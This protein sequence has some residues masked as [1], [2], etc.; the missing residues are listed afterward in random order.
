VGRIHSRGLQ[1]MAA[2]G[3]AALVCAAFAAQASAAGTVVA[4]WH[5]DET[6]GSTMRDSAG[7]ADGTLHNVRL[8]QRGKS[9]NA[10]GFNGSSSYV[11]VSAAAS[12]SLNPGSANITITIYGK[13][14]S[15][16]ARPDFDLIRKGAYGTGP[17]WKVEL[18]PSGQASCGFG[19]TSGS[20]EVIGVGPSIADGRWHKV[21]CKKT[22]TAIKMTVDGASFSRS[23]RIGSIS[24]GSQL[25][26]GSS[27]TID[28]YKGLLDEAS[29]AIG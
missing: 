10:Y 14:T 29:V 8:G 2:A 18:Q 9:G 27:P 5:M 22:G 3:G 24:S 25:I 23:I 21:Q 11:S 19:G 15:V 13:T 26:V 1:W 7:S 20:A 6:S 16:P 4:L 28:W 17:G 12:A